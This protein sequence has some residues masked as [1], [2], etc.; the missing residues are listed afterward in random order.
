MGGKGSGHPVCD[1][2]MAC[3]HKWEKEWRDGNAVWKLSE[4][5]AEQWKRCIKCKKVKMRRI[6]P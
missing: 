4:I 6:T 5:V 3:W 2:I 1:E